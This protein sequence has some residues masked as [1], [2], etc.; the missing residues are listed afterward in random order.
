VRVCVFFLK[1][2]ELLTNDLPTITK[3]SGAAL[4]V[5]DIH[6]N[7]PN[8]GNI[9]LLNGR[10]K[11]ILSILLSKIYCQGVCRSLS[12]CL[13]SGVSTVKNLAW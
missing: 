8:Y 10:N 7:Q 11:R 2:I 4:L 5:S 3:G 6:I 1:S 12:R 9:F 13:R